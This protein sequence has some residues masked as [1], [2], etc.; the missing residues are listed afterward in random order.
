MKPRTLV[1]A[2]LWAL[3]VCILAFTAH[4]LRAQ[5]ESAAKQLERLAKKAKLRDYGDLWEVARDI[6][7]LGDE[8]IDALE[9][10]LPDAGVKERLAFDAALFELGEADVASEDILSLVGNEKADVGARVAAASLLEAQGDRRDA[11]KLFENIA[12]YSEPLVRIAVCRAGYKKLREVEATRILREYAASAEYDVRAEAAVALAQLDDFENSKEIL[13][14][15]SREPTRRGQ[16]ARSL[17]M[18]D[19]LYQEAM[20][21]AGLSRDQLLKS[22]DEKINELKAEVAKL[23]RE[24]DE[25]TATG[26]KLLDELL[27]RIRYYYVDEDKI[28]SSRLIDSA[29]KGMVGSLDRYSSYMDERETKLFYENLTQHYS[30]IGARVSK[31]I[32][33]YMLIES[34]IYSGPAYRAGLRSGDKITKVDGTD[35][36][37]LSLE[38]IVDKLKGKEGTT[39][40]ITV[41]RTGWP[42]DRDFTIVRE[43][44][45]LPSVRYEMLPGKIG[46]LALS[47]FGREAVQEVENALD[48]LEKQ[49]MKALIFDLRFNPGGLL[50]AAVKVADKFLS[51]RKLIVSSKGRNPFV[52]PEQKKYSTDEGTHPDFPLYVLVNKGSASASEIFAGAMQ[53]HKR[54]KVIGETTFGKG[55]VQQLFEVIAT[56]KKTR[57]RLTIA[58]YYLPSGRSIHREEGSDEGGVTP[59]IESV[60]PDIPAGQYTSALKL[61]EEDVYVKYL[62]KHYADNREVFHKLAVSDAGDPS[63]Y[64]G[65]EEWYKS[66]CTDLDR[67][68]VRFFLRREARQKV[69][70]DL[71]N[72]LVSDIGD[73][74]V[75]QRGIVEVLKGLDL[76][77]EKIDEYKG[78]ADKFKEEKL[79]EE[80]PKEEKPSEK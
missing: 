71:G 74:Y 28:D 31:K 6:A 21:A 5:E 69:A 75:L 1:S 7:K 64:P 67:D 14:D 70:D 2:L 61:Q 12:K 50:D 41:R 20:S 49:G 9:E 73:D 18:Q 59:D 34:P 62:E 79:K 45:D 8:V 39:V 15:V 80:K 72:E 66:L 58:K 60:Q 68:W 44:I 63:R 3:L 46:Y 40:V 16:L 65:F 36:L 13:K 11:R 32:E 29:A 23:K 54:A 38:E 78:F 24:K 17:L 25:A 51:G 76:D 26:I 22:K 37:R 52:A 19:R 53:E 47:G 27:T 10:M 4:E 77:P 56:D 35:I 33:D 30:G 48:D 43:S 42:E 55:S 57:L